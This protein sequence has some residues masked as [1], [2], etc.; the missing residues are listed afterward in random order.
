MLEASIECEYFE[1]VAEYQIAVCKK[2]RHAVIPSHIR[3]HLRRVHKAKLRQAEEIAEKVGDWPGVVK[4]ASEIAVP[5]HAIPAIHELPVYTDGLLCQL[6]PNCRQILRSTTA[7]R[8]HW[9]QAHSWMP[10]GAKGRPSR[11]ARQRIQT[12]SQQGSR[13]VYCQR[14]FIQGPGSQYFEVQPPSQDQEG[15]STVPVDGGTAWACLSEQMAKA[16]EN[17]EKRVNKTIQEG[18]RDEVNPWVER[19]Q[20]LPYLVGIERADLMA[21][22]E[23]PVAEPDPRNNGKGEPVEAAIWAAMAGLT[24]FSQASVIKR[25]GVF[26]QLEVIRTEKHQTRYQPLQPYMNK[27]AIVKHTRPWQ[28]VLMFFARTQKEHEWKS[29]QYRF[30][31]RQQEAWEALSRKAEAAAGEV[32]E[33]V[34]EMDEEEEADA[35]EEQGRAKGNQAVKLS[36]I[37]KACLRFCIALLNDRITSREYDSPLVCALAVLGVKEDGWKGP[38]QYPPILSAMIK[39]AR[40]M[41]VQ[42]GLEL[43]DL[44]DKSSDELE[45]DSVYESDPSRQRPKGCLQ[46]V[47]Q[48][49]DR[50][51]V[52]GSHGPMQWMLDLRTYGLKIHYNTTSHRHVEWIRRDELLYKELHFSMAQFHGMVHGLA[53]E[54][55][56]LLTEELLFSSKAGAVPIIP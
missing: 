5:E 44:I 15:P 46:L 21:C 14:L 54:S 17:V 48:M 32:E 42:Q 50:F 56:R 51:M 47:K 9:K 16:W 31:R 43:A 26:V 10:A 28:Q 12:R 6:D 29:P 33:E 52:R 25:V 53:S 45:D 8:N 41:V 23:E 30:R 38:E 35:D 19:T 3:S 11:V 36:S 55:R 22:I 37:Q 13:L 1:H 24:R 40:F 7:I 34:D 27:G 20:W 4:Y 49:M 39:I 2:C 18:E